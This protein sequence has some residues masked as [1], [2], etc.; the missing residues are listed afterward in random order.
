MTNKDVSI[1]IGGE[2]EG[3]EASMARAKTIVRTAAT[4]MHGSLEK[5][6][7]SFEKVQGAMVLMTAAL[8][9]GAAFKE[10]I[11]ATV[12][13]TKDSVVLGRQLGIGATQ[14][15]ILKAALKEVHAT[16]DQFT[17]ATGR[18]TQTLNKNEGAF[19]KL[20]VATRDSNGNY[21]NSVDIML[22]VNK[23]L[24]QLKEGTDRNVAG[25]QIFG[26]SWS[27][28][29]PL[30][31]LNAEAMA[32][33]QRKASA[34][35]LVV[36]QED[37]AAVARY[38]AAMVDSTEVVEGL[39]KT[40]GDA[41][42]PALTASAEWLSENG[43]AAVEI[44]RHAMGGVVTEIIIVKAVFQAVFAGI[45]AWLK[46]TANSFMT[47]GDIISCAMKGDFSGAK[48][49]WLKG[50]S[51]LADTGKSFADQLREIQTSA[52]SDVA[53]AWKKAFSPQPK[54][55]AGPG[56]ASG[57]AEPSGD[58]KSKGRVPAWQTALEESKAGWQAAQ[59]AE[60]SFRE[61]SKQQE[62]EYWQAILSTE[63]T[64]SQEQI[65]IRSKIAQLALSLDKEKFS[66]EVETLKTEEDAYHANGEARLEIAR[67]LA[68]RMR[69][70]YGDESKEY[71][72]ARKEVL[73]IE[74]QIQQQLEQVRAAHAESARTNA[75]VAIDA[76]EEQVREQASLRQ[77]SEAQAIEA[78][79][80]FE[81]RRMEIRRQAL[82]EQLQIAARD[83][84]RDPV[85]I[86]RIHAQMEELE[87]KH[88]AALGKI[89][90]KELLATTSDWRGAMSSIQGG[91][92]NAFSSMAKGQQSFAAGTKAMTASVVWSVIDM[93]TTMLAKWLI[94]QLAQIAGVKTA[95]LSTISAHAGEAASGAYAATAAIPYVGPALAPAAAATAFMGAM[96]YSA[97]LS[98]AGGYDIPSGIAPV[99]Q[100]HQREMVLPASLADGLRDIIAG[101]AT[102]GRGMT[103][104][105]H[106]LDQHSVRKFMDNPENQRAMYGAVMK[107][108]GRRFGPTGR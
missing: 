93:L 46:A 87:A 106:A 35:G 12:N 37:V 74:R 66:A 90:R 21:R 77:I 24:G 38:R 98:A 96:S 76:E 59:R 107:H 108:S 47:L 62:L 55:A 32:E 75:M 51:N 3:L 63:K 10:A 4:E 102:G 18:I 5:L 105:I 6:K 36:G 72:N 40:I 43:P 17:A 69:I 61:F 104:H 54:T 80:A 100:L 13:L 99:T 34:L 86:A 33:A 58:P 64:N 79:R 49:A 45:G 29:E 11:A 41:L 92:A 97:A 42:L 83:P 26:R 2:P 1:S 78:E 50:W 73:A 101:G 85:A 84:D 48:D 94:T 22:D 52:A 103:V 7:S 68:E 20:G 25:V 71:A 44:F 23:A 9:G 95:G 39:E 67:Q 19:A 88:Q 60:G 82:Q 30:I 8:A 70:A 16:Q 31:R 14:A 27:S 81:A 89:R 91:F 56:A 53:D 15:S 57:T 28:V 65:S